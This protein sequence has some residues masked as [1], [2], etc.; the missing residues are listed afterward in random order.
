M[1]ISQ[2]PTVQFTGKS[3]R[4]NPDL[5]NYNAGDTLI[6][7]SQIFAGDT[8]SY[9]SQAVKILGI[10][11]HEGKTVN[12][13][14]VPTPPETHGYVGDSVDLVQYETQDG[15]K[16]ELLYGTYGSGVD[17]MD[18]IKRGNLYVHQ[19]DEHGQPIW[20][21]LIKDHGLVH[22]S[23]LTVPEYIQETEQKL[24]DSERALRR[25]SDYATQTAHQLAGIQSL[26][27]NGFMAAANAVMAHVKAQ[28][29]SP[30]PAKPEAD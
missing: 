30:S 8:V 5:K 18:S 22:K 24:T 26:F 2:R 27:N 9:K 17:V 4:N 6:L 15:A 11:P 16:K 12:G 10:L 20:V 28:T 29:P 1:K 14:T 25:S 13:I 7:R 21:K 23:F 19:L 3:Q